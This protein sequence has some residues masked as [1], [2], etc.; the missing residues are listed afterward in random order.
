[1]SIVQ[2]YCLQTGKKYIGT[3]N[4][5]NTV[6]D[7]YIKQK[8]ELQEQQEQKELKKDIEKIIEDKT[9]KAFNDIFNK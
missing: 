2:R 4:S 5:G 8:K 9:T 3:S 6:A 7:R 1:M